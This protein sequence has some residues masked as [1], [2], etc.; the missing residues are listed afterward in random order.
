[1]YKFYEIYYND[2]DWH[3]F[4]RPEYYIAKNEEEVKNSSDVYKKLLKRKEERGGSLYIFEHP[5]D[6]KE[7][8][9]AFLENGE[10]FD[11]TINIKEKE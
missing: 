3:T 9:L 4:S 8:R 11:I 7:L 10:K 2:G 5:L 1:M 6:F